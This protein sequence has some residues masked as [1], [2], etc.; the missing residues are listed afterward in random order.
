MATISLCM[1]VKNEEEVLARC[2]NSAK[3]AVDEIIIVDTGSTDSTREIAQSFT[4]Q[5]YSFDWIDDFSAARNYSF[6]KAAMDYCMWLDA[7]DVLEEP[8]RLAELKKELTCQMVMMPYRVG[9]LTYYRERLIRRDGG[10]KWEG[11]VHEAISP[12]GE[13]IYSDISVTHRKEKATDPDRNLRIYEKELAAG[14][15]LPPRDQFYYARE[16]T[17]HGKEAAAAEI[18]E[19]MLQKGEGWLENLLEACRLLG[20]CRRKMGDPEKAKAALLHSFS[21]AAPRAEICCDLGDL[22]F[23]K[24]DYFTAIFWY[25]TAAQ[26]PRPDRSGGFVLPDRYG[27]YPALQLCVCC[28]RIGEREKAMAWNEYA[29]A[30]QPDHPA[31]LFNR[32]FFQQ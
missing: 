16:L 22:F 29:A 13:I 8:Q 4:D 3:D 5:V 32:R 31:V 23:E 17:Y 15:V 27:L 10:M 25:E 18:L 11:A 2:L 26:R 30:E 6:S 9:G 19:E 20:E 28:Y 21:L 24:E 12:V 1:I 7:D 14:K